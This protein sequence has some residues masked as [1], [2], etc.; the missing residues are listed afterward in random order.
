MSGKP[1]SNSF[2][3]ILRIIFVS[4]LILVIALAGVTIYAVYHKD[5]ISATIIES[6]NQRTNANIEFT[7]IH[8]SPLTNFPLLSITLNDLVVA[9][10]QTDSLLSDPI[11]QLKK[12]H[13]G[14]N[15]KE[16]LANSIDIEGFILEDGFVHLATDEDRRLNL[17]RTFRRNESILSE[18]VRE[19]EEMEVPDSLKKKNKINFSIEKFRLKNVGLKFYGKLSNK[20]SHIVVDD[21]FA[22]YLTNSDSIVGTLETQLSILEA[23][24][25][26]LPI[27]NEDISLKTNLSV[28][29]LDSVLHIRSGEATIGKAE[30]A[31][32]GD[33]DYSSNQTVD[34]ELRGKDKSLGL[35]SLFLS[36]M[37]ISNITQ[38]NI[39]FVA[40]AKGSFIE[41]IPVVRCRFGID[42]L[43]VKIPDHDASISNLHLSGY[44]NSGRKQNLSDAKLQIDTIYGNLPGGLI[45]ACLELTDFQTPFVRYAIDVKSHLKGMDDILQLEIIDNLDGYIEITDSYAGRFNS[46]RHWFDL[47]NKELFMQFQDVSFSIPEIINVQSVNGE[48]SGFLDS[49]SFNALHV[50]SDETDL[51][52]NGFV[53]GGSYLLAPGDSVLYADLAIIGKRFN[54]P[55]ALAFDPRIGESFPYPVDD[56]DLKVKMKTEWTALTDTSAS[57]HMVFDIE[58]LHALPK[59]FLPFV[60]IKNGHFDLFKKNDFNQLIFE[61]FD[62]DMA[63]SKVNADVKLG[64]EEDRIINYDI[65]GQFSDFNLME[66][67]EGYIASQDTS[68]MFLNGDF[69][70][71]ALQAEDSNSTFSASNIQVY[72]LLIHTPADTIKAE[73]LTMSAESIG[74]GNSSKRFQSASVLSGRFEVHSFLS[75]NGQFPKL[76][77]TVNLNNGLLEGKNIW[78]AEL[79]KSNGINF[80]YNTQFSIPRFSLNSEIRQLK[81]QRIFMFLKQ[82]TLMSG[83]VDLRLNVEMSGNS[84]KEMVSSLDGDLAVESRNLRLYGTE[85]DP[86]IK[87]FKRSQTFNLVDVGALVLTGPIGIAVT[88]GSDYTRLLLG[89]NGEYTNIPHLNSDWEFEDGRIT[90]KDVAF[91]TENNRIAAHGI[92]DF[93]TDSINTRIALIDKDGCI[94]ASQDVEGTILNPELS[95]MNIIQTILAP[96]KNLLDDA[97]FSKCD[98]FYNGKVKHPT[99]TK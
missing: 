19:E 45:N 3:L 60:K 85:L 41:Q 44:F 46:N 73:K 92:Y 90:M 11:I 26:G 53:K 36:D 51:T 39:T 17:I 62:I 61:H 87:K 65:Q 59:G 35:T 22:S 37:G 14:I 83:P 13:L 24:Y 20:T 9:E 86:L 8:I 55:V 2:K 84:F 15:I 63:G 89:N 16:L 12:L 52:I 25:S 38:G 1:G 91:A 57:P 69:S 79:G 40:H 5:E 27:T 48:L 99:E 18:S 93:K 7:S 31:L 28:N 56:L 34:M 49:V 23:E 72:N 68:K 50:L 77:G 6:V 98:P 29:V 42:N 97:T 81:L 58:K 82:D 47:S 30:F 70:F 94:V 43:N 71:E 64:W 76:T 10:K 67:K 66:L 32:S 21:L 33:F 96:V 80:S 54:L 78:F 74:V 75:G 88:K 95:G 4:L